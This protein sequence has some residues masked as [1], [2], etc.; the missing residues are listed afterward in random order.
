MKNPR[1]PGW[2]RYWTLTF[3]R[4]TAGSVVIGGHCLQMINGWAN[5]SRFQTSPISVDGAVPNRSKRGSN[6]EEISILRPH[7]R[8]KVD[9]GPIV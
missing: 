4:S 1:L 2:Q 3:P 9:N 8:W 7:G 6:L 5:R